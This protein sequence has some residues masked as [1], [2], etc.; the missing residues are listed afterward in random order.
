MPHDLRTTVRRAINLVEG[1]AKQ[2]GVAIA[3]DLPAA[4][5]TVDGDPEQ[6]HQVLVNLLLNGIEA[7]PQGGSLD[8]AVQAGNGAGNTCRVSVSDSGTGIPQPVL[9]RI[10]EPFVTSKERGTGLGLAISHRIAVEHSGTLLA[11]NRPEGGAVFT[12]ELPMSGAD[13]TDADAGNNRRGEAQRP[14]PQ[15]TPA[16]TLN[17]NLEPGTQTRGAPC[18]DSW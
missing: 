16:R 5:V 18:Q 13:C 1:R 17:P 14:E 3:T 6:L 9:D 10:F 4:A 15:G 12:V 2:Q 11:A 8:V 7:M